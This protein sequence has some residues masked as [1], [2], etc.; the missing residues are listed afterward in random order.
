MISPEMAP[1]I[2]T[3]HN[4]DSTSGKAGFL[5]LGFEC[6]ASGRTILRDWERRVPLIVQQALYFDE[7]L[8]DMACVYILSSGGPNVEGDRHEQIFTLRRGAMVH[9]STGAATKIAEMHNDYSSLT[10]RLRMEADSYLEYLPEPI[11]PCRHSRYI[12]RTLITISP[13]ATLVY[14]EIYLCGRRYF[15]GGECFDYDILSVAV[16][17]ERD[18]GELLFREKFIIEPH[19]H[20]PQQAGAMGHYTI[21][22][23]VIMLGEESAVADIYNAQMP[24]IDSRESLATGITLLP[25][26]CGVQYKVLGNST[27]SVKREVRSFFSKVRQRVKHRPLDD[28]FAWR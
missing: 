27:D 14:G 5:R 21:F 1:Y 16:R 19:R 8:P 11:I 22:A 7:Q 9:L 23:N 10:Q 4:A 25:E 17:A 13:T 3:P 2:S 12:A 20:N 15:G 28:E 6:D 18:S 24:G 26:G